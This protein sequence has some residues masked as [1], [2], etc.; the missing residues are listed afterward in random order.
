MSETKRWAK[1]AAAAILGASAGVLLYQLEKDK[2]RKNKERLAIVDAAIVRSRS[3]G[4]QKAYIIGNSLSSLAAAVWLLKDGHFPG[5][6]IT[7]FGE[8]EK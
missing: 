6:R 2:K 5:N 8:V 4:E 1:L 3:Y 7:V